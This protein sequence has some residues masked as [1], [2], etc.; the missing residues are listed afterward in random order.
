[1][2]ELNIESEFND[3]TVRE[4]RNES[5]YNAYEE[6]TCFSDNPSIVSCSVPDPLYDGDTNQQNDLDARSFRDEDHKSRDSLYHRR[7]LKALELY[8]EEDRCKDPEDRIDDPGDFVSVFEDF[9]EML[10]FLPC[11]D[12]VLHIPGYGPI[13]QSGQWSDRRVSQMGILPP[14][15]LAPDV[16]V[17]IE[18]LANTLH[19]RLPSRK[20]R[21]KFLET[22]RNCTSEVSEFNEMFQNIGPALKRTLD[23]GTAAALG[24]TSRIEDA[25]SF[26]ALCNNVV[27]IGL[28][29]YGLYRIIDGKSTRDYVL[30]VAAILASISTIG[31]DKI[32]SFATSIWD[33][34]VKCFAK[35][36]NFF[37]GEEK[38]VN[39]QDMD[40]I[41]A[42]GAT[43][44]VDG[45][46]DSL[47]LAYSSYA[48][49]S[50]YINQDRSFTFARDFS[51]VLRAKEGL[52]QCC[53]SI[54][55]LF[56]RTY[57]FIIAEKLGFDPLHISLSGN[58][59]VEQYEKECNSIFTEWGRKELTMSE[60]NLERITALVKAGEE[61]YKTCSTGR[62]TA[63]ETKL[64]YDTLNRLR[65]IKAKYEEANI[66]LSGFKFESIFILFVGCPGVFKS[67]IAYHASGACAAMDLSEKR[68]SEFMVNFNNF[69]F[70]RQAEAEYWQ[71]YDPL[72]VCTLFDDLGQQKDVAGN[73]DNE[74][75]NII[76][77]VNGF[78]YQLHMADMNAKG[79]TTFRSKFVI[80]TTNLYEFKPNSIISAE[81]L[82]R[83]I[84]FNVVVTPKAKYCADPN[85]DRMSQKFN[86]SLLPKD[87]DGTLIVTP[88]ICD[89]HL[90]DKK[91]KFTG[92]ILNFEQ[93]MQRVHELYKEHHRR[94]DMHCKLFK[95]TAL[96]YR[97]MFFPPP[98]EKPVAQTTPWEADSGF[99]MSDVDV[100]PPLIDGSTD[101]INDLG[102]RRR[103][104]VTEMDQN[105]A[106]LET[107][108]EDDYEL[109]KK[110][111][112]VYSEVCKTHIP[113]F[114]AGYMEAI[115]RHLEAQGRKEIIP[116]YKRLSSVYNR[117]I[118]KNEALVYKLSLKCDFGGRSIR[119]VEELFFS[120]FCY[121]I[122]AACLFLEIE[123]LSTLPSFP[124]VRIEA[125]LIPN[126]RDDTTP[127]KSLLRTKFH[128]YYE[129]IQRGFKLVIT[130]PVF[131]A[132]SALGGLTYVFNKFRE[133]KQLSVF[134]DNNMSIFDKKIF[135]YVNPTACDDYVR[136][137]FA[138]G[139]YHEG[140]SNHTPK[141]TTTIRGLKGLMKKNVAQSGD[142]TATDII[143][144]IVNNNIYEMQI[145]EI[146]GKKHNAGFIMFL[147]GTLA[148][149]PFHYMK[150]WESAILE[151]N[152]RLDAKVLLIQKGNVR[153][154]FTVEEIID[155]LFGE[156][157]IENDLVGI[158]F[159]M[160]L[161]PRTDITKF[162]ISENMLHLMKSNV[163]VSGIWPRK[164][165]L[166]VITSQALIH[167][168][169]IS[170]TLSS[171]KERYEVMRTVEYSANTDYGDCGVPILAHGPKFQHKRILGIHVAGH[172][173]TQK[174]YAAL[175]TQEDL[176]RLLNELEE[177][178]VVEDEVDS[179]VVSQG[180]GNFAAV[181]PEINKRFT[182]IGR[183]RHF[184]SQPTKTKYVKSPLYNTY[185]PPTE[186]PGFLKNVN[187]KSV[188]EMA[189]AKFAIN[190]NK[191]DT[192]RLTKAVE[193]YKAMLQSRPKFW[194][195][196]KKELL[197]L[198]TALWGED[199]NRYLQ[200]MNSKTSPGAFIKFTNPKFKEQIF[201]ENARR[202]S[203]NP[204]LKVIDREVRAIVKKASNS[205][206]MIWVFTDNI[207]DARLDITKALAGKGRLFSGCPFYYFLVVRIY[208]GAFSAA[209]SEHGIDIESCL[210]MNVHS[211][212]WDELARRLGK[213]STKRYPDVVAGDQSKFDGSEIPPVHWEILKII[214]EWYNDG[215][216]NSLI[217]VILWY[218]VVNSRHLFGDIVYE[219]HSSLPSGHPLTTLINCMY[220][221]IAFRFSWYGMPNVN[222]FPELFH[223]YVILYVLGDD[224]VLSIRDDVVEFFNQITIE[225]LM[226]DLG[227]TYT[228]ENKDLNAE[229]TPTRPLNEIEF[230]KRGFRF[231]E[232]LNKYVCPLRLK[233]VLEMPQWSRK[234]DYLPISATNLENA[235][236][237]L[238][239]HDSETYSFWIEKFSKAASDFLPHSHF[240]FPI[241]ERQMAKLLR[242]RGASSF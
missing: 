189:L 154:S 118:F 182:V 70:N 9:F 64:L 105:V 204:I 122:Q 19:D 89:F 62:D 150:E 106:S 55:K 33:T 153:F 161:P 155:G 97:N 95:E 128:G 183:S 110:L 205:E 218:E 241:K 209:F 225:G 32:I 83:R 10:L 31:I 25:G 57:N 233:V 201:G 115:E 151:N 163:L 165:T 49:I 193:D 113:L 85:R 79:V 227:L 75:M 16:K 184:H 96:K 72:K 30:G 179:E 35:F 20:E 39:M 137:K 140:R 53:K 37:K 104:E 42:Q 197:S 199:G 237:E 84:H 200:A 139:E 56:E 185:S 238:A 94:Y 125:V 194:N 177:T 116:L 27:P 166:E 58:P 135:T 73:P 171:T 208:F 190:D 242:R 136:E 81:A 80:A 100:P 167:T 149:A 38:E 114:E 5:S 127:V 164:E 240:N 54:L 103:T 206:R 69:I 232:R 223:F 99:E 196:S 26:M 8:M 36:L 98:A 175:V 219:W 112:D 198:E 51:G 93:L 156:S 124:L 108:I 129:A 216:V 180:A 71:G 231:E 40:G 4:S 214:N 169:P 65:T 48:G 168:V 176:E 159:P 3:Y 221:S 86:L 191:I 203:S 90:R 46:L 192:V 215:P 170:V 133:P 111:N 130:N 202:D 234:D 220:N 59:L 15:D 126:S 146:D 21:E 1:M 141:K 82:N 148:L 187:G 226:K 11:T 109:V 22:F 157:L 120:L 132:A 143:Q 17:K 213:F 13:A 14:I 239:Y 24:A 172:E 68:F 138:Q 76:R 178:V 236:S 34:I 123:K 162:F 217:R 121:N 101:S 67:T 52:L 41:T 117:L 47:S 142:Q 44:F 181:S 152:N 188:Y 235:A 207:K 160:S 173:H 29:A 92:E 147:K 91:N 2:Y 18:D 66:H 63:T 229:L 60:A 195:E 131:L 28:F 45:I 43:D 119:S 87:E 222:D 211:D 74:Y 78:E 6:E 144:K 107:E 23:A 102:Y 134:V 61:L 7:R 210:N 212:E 174:G 77:A 50:S 88:D 158:K 230:L 145:E 186:M 224:N 228:S 12:E